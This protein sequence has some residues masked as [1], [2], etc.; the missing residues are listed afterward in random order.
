M[1]SF[2][3]SKCLSSFSS[4]VETSELH[5]SLVRLTGLFTK[6]LRMFYKT[7]PWPTSRYSFLATRP[8]SWC[9]SVWG[10]FTSSWTSALASSALVT[11]KPGEGLITMTR[12]RNNSTK[13][14]P[15]LSSWEKC[16]KRGTGT[17]ILILKTVKQLNKSQILHILHH[18]S[19]S[20]TQCS[21][22]LLECLWVLVFAAFWDFFSSVRD[23]EETF[24]SP[25][26]GQWSPVDWFT[27]YFS[28]VNK[29]S[30][31]QPWVFSG[32]I[33]APCV[34]SL[35]RYQALRPE[36]RERLSRTGASSRPS[37]DQ[38]RNSGLT[39]LSRTWSKITCHVSKYHAEE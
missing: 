16:L 6:T 10:Q 27:D 1:W 12:T 31:H 4:N 32:T 9:C 29:Y 19:L 5:N 37:T 13:L 15:H 22:L 2:S 17:L 18:Y 26:T 33:L 24:L 11:S 3:P 20:S 35:C 28:V 34:S 30:E 38:Q 36:T 14:T 21:C 39:N 8:L 25:C 7:I 23:A